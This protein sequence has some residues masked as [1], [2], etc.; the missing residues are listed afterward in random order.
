MP[1]GDPF[2]LVTPTGAGVAAD[3]TQ[4]APPAPPLVVQPCGDAG[5]LAGV[6]KPPKLRTPKARP[7]PWTESAT[8]VC[9][10]APP[11]KKARR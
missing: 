5:G 11:K 1:T 2:K 8:R 7:A 4:P 6:P 3:I 9:A 10:A